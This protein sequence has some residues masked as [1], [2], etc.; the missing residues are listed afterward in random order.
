MTDEQS[1][2]VAQVAELLQLTEKHVRDLLNE[3]EIIGYKLGKYWRI[4]R[5]DLTAYINEKKAEQQ[6][7]HQ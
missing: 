1:L 7:N 3:G 4:D 2:T 5:P 6:A